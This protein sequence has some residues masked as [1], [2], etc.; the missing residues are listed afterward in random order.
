[1]YREYAE[2]LSKS[3]PKDVDHYHYF[4]YDTLL[5]GS[6]ISGLARQMSFRQNSPAMGSVCY[7]DKQ[8][9]TAITEWMHSDASTALV[10][11]FG[12]Y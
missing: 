2:S 4:S 12:N 6:K 9:R 7:P 8:Y 10:R 5:S 11:S 3:N 1:M